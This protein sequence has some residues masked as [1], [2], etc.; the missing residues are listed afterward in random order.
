MKH[1]NPL[2]RIFIGISLIFILTGCNLFSGDSENQNSNTS[3]A[4]AP[5]KVLTEMVKA[6]A[7]IK[8]SKMTFSP[9]IKVKSDQGDFDFKVDLAGKYNAKDTENVKTELDIKI[10][11]DVDMDG[12]SGSASV[13]FSFKLI[14]KKAFF[15][16]NELVLPDQYKPF[17]AM[18]QSVIDEYTNKWISLPSDMMPPEL[19][20]QIKGDEKLTAKQE[21]IKELAEESPLLTVVKD[22][23]TENIN[24]INTYHYDTEFN[25]ENFKKLLVEVSKIEEKEISE[26][27]L[28]D[29][30][31]IFKEMDIKLEL[32]IGTEDYL[33][34]QGNIA[35][36]GQ[37]S[38]YDVDIVMDWTG[39]DF[40]ETF[41]IKA[42]TDTVTFE[43]LMKAYAES[44]P[45]MPTGMPEMQ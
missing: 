14:D 17:L 8:T 1:F 10:A 41:D 30:D 39:S 32:W 33:P 24:G 27:Q 18:Y 12:Q 44:A 4:Q 20:K 22:H 6:S 26:S 38:E 11:G 34:Y 16:L 43:D 25:V 42:P 2:F 21:K 23:G 13:G 40:N 28:S 9:H 36:K 3:D 35:L 31:R 37:D 29:I 19:Q 15:K 5:E 7:D 45:T